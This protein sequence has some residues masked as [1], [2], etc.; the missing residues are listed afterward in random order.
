MNKFKTFLATIVALLCSFS[1]GAYDFEKDGIYYTITTT[2]SF[3]NAVKVT[4]RGNSAEEYSNEYSGDVTIPSE[5]TYNNKTYSVNNIGYGA[6]LDCSGITSIT[7]PK[8]VTNIGQYAFS[9]CTGELVVNCDIPS[10]SYSEKYGA[11]YNSE[12]T[13]VTIGATVTSFGSYAFKKCFALRELVIEDSSDALSMGNLPANTEGLFYDCPLVS[14]YLGR[15]LSGATRDYSPFYDNRYTLK[16]VVIGDGATGIGAYTFYGCFGLTSITIPESVTSIEPYAFY[17]CNLSSITIPESVTWIDSYAFYGCNL[18]SITIP[19]SVV[20]IG[21]YAFYSNSITS[22]T[23]LAAIPPRIYSS[24]FDENICSTSVL[25]VPYSSLDAYK[26]DSYWSKCYKKIGYK[27]YTLT[28]IVDGEIVKKESVPYGNTIASFENPTKE[29]YTFSGWSEI[30]ETMPAEDVTVYGTFTINKYYV[31]FALDG[32]VQKSELL[33]YGATIVAP[34]FPEREGYTLTWSEDVPATVPA[35]D[36]YYNAVYVANIY[37]VYYFVGSDLVHVADVPYGEKI[38]E[39]IYE[40]KEG[41]EV[42]LGWL[43]NEYEIMPAHDIY[44]TAEMAPVGIEKLIGDGEQNT[45]IYDLQGCRVL[46]NQN[47]KAGIYIVNGKKV[48][49]K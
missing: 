38:P 28:Y 43:G 2:S 23:C 20:S 44:L 19:E 40:P 35:M 21:K 13:K 30:P 49:L 41:E 45:V 34:A 9:G 10:A 7:I 18:S 8:S 42:F 22:I 46:D 12:F 4:Y 3:Y 37:Q 6:F 14:V 36:V 27:T 15:K 32:V 17:G 11:F 5:V 29:G 33:E 47:L 16:N 25:Y 39:Y 31:T 48:V 26:N 1:V 24:T